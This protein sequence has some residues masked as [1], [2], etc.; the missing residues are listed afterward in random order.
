MQHTSH[1]MAAARAASLGLM[2]LVACQ[3]RPGGG[4][5]SCMHAQMPRVGAPLAMPC[6]PGQRHALHGGPLQCACLYM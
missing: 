1:A 6:M 3:R 4:G 5:G 2:L